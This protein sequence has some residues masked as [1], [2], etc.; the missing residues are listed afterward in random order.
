MSAKSKW[1]AVVV[2]IVLLFFI[3]HKKSTPVM[4]EIEN[5]NETED[6]T[7]ASKDQTKSTATTVSGDS[8]QVSPLPQAS[9]I[10]ASDLEKIAQLRSQAKQALAASFTA[11]VSFRVEYNQ[12]ST[13]LKAMGFYPMGNT[14]SYKAGFL[15]PYPTTSA[16]LNLSTDAYLETSPYDTLAR[17]INLA[18]YA[19]YCE[20]GCTANDGE[21][22]MLLVLPLLNEKRVDVWLINEK[23]EMKQ[24]VDGLQ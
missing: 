2:G 9:E 13:D 6:T 11:E 5:N 7:P 22:E 15:S 18:D 14:L 19:K 17:Q 10:S 21:F 24:V 3:L 16:E 8:T 12:Y 4:T 23:K 20:R 1:I